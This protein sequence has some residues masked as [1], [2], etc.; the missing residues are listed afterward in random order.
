MK[1]N[2]LNE[3]MLTYATVVAMTVR[4]AFANWINDLANQTKNARR[5]VQL[6]TLASRTDPHWSVPWYNLG[7]QTKY[8][9]DWKQSVRFNQRAVELNPANEGA[10]WNL[11]IAATAL[12]DWKEARRAWRGF[13]VELN[14]GTGE[15]SMPTVAG[16]VR[17]N[18]KESGEVVWGERLD[19]AR[20][21]VLNVPLPESKRRFRDVIL[22][23]GAENGSRMLDG[24]KIGVFDELEVWQP[25][26]YSTFQS[27]LHVPDPESEEKLR[28]ISQDHEVGVEDWSTIRM[29]CAECSRGNPQPHE[30]KAVRPNGERKRFG[31]GAHKP[32]DV[33]RVL[34]QWVTASRGA[35]YKNVGLALAATG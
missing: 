27:E 16:C 35:D 17:L 31:F 28:K 6:Y 21:V 15:V 29:I 32:E 22:N 23:D 3:T 26:T 5:A 34:I 1:S 18:P 4:H 13:G 14:E 11:G 25:S 7:L 9:G 2:R 33:E 8:L 10:W 12:H 24:L 20:I 30:C 19:P